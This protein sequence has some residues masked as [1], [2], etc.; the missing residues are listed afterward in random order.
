MTD[1]VNVFV[2]GTLKRPELLKSLCGKGF[3]KKKMQLK[4]HSLHQVKLAGFPGIVPNEGH[5]VH[6]VILKGV[7]PQQLARLDRYEAEGTLYHR[8]T[9]TVH[10]AKGNEQQ[11]ETYVFAN[12]NHLEKEVIAGEW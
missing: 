5:T 10:D 7:T 3:V 12:Q 11:A 8:R 4:D 2:Y 1:K 6:G 9:V